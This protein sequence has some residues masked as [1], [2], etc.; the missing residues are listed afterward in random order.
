MIRL[1][2][3][4]TEKSKPNFLNR[5]IIGFAYGLIQSRDL[6]LKENFGFTLQDAM[7]FISIGIGR[8]IVK[9]LLA[10]NV[11]NKNDDDEKLIGKLTDVMRL[12]EELD[13]RIV[14]EKIKLVVQKCLICPKRIGG[15]D[16]EG[17]TACPIG[18]IIVGALTYVRGLYP[19]ITKNKLEIAE[20]C[21][22]QL[23]YN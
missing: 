1:F 6:I 5:I 10:Q 7:D 12:A 16:L 9:E 3:K 13:I 17:F 4:K 8:E 19:E 11:V 20:I 21:H 15:Y 2:L 22:I 23:E 18:G 14:N